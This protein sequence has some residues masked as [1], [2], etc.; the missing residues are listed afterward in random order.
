MEACKGRD[1][2]FLPSLEDYFAD[3]MRQL[4][5][6]V[7]EED[8]ILKDSNTG[9]RALRLLARRSP[10]FF[11]YNNTILNP[12][13]SYLEMMVRKI[14]HEKRGKDNQDSQNDNEIENILTEEEQATEDLKPNDNEEFVDDNNLNQE[15]KN[16]TLNQLLLISE[17]VAPDWPKLAVKLGLY[18]SFI[19]S[20]EIQNKEL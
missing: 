3:A 9:W 19:Y 10:H 7:K 4:E 16:L 12:L 2:D 17:K 1:R 5:S 13:S 8:S 6:S 14:S 11:T 18:Y 15:H 20:I